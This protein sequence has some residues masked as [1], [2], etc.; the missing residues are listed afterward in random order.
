MER[1]LERFFWRRPP[2]TGELWLAS[3]IHLAASDL[4][5]AERL[6]LESFRLPGAN[7]D[8]KNTFTDDAPFR[9]LV[10]TKA[11]ARVVA[12]ARKRE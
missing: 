8:H 6:A 7:V 1:E 4:E 12:A 3:A 5:G 2:Q 9:V 10:D 11:W